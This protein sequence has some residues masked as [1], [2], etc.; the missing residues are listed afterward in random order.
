MRPRRDGKGPHCAPIAPPLRPHARSR[1]SDIVLTGFHNAPAVVGR[2]PCGNQPTWSSPSRRRSVQKFVSRVATVLRSG[3]CR[4]RPRHRLHPTTRSKLTRCPAVPTRDRRHPC[5]PLTKRQIPPVTPHLISGHR[6]HSSPISHETPE[7]NERALDLAKRLRVEGVACDIDKFEVSPPEG[8][9][10]WMK[11]QTQE[12]DFVI[13]VCTETYARRFAGNETSGKGKGAAREGLLIDQSLYDSGENHRFI[14]VVFDQTDVDHIPPVLKNATYYDLSTDAGYSGLHRALTN[15][16]RFVRRPLGPIPKRLSDLDPH[17]SK[18]TE[19]LHLCPDPLPLE[20][21][22]RVVGQEVSEVATT[23]QRLVN[24]DVVKIEQNVVRREERSAD[25]IPVPSDNVVGSALEAALDFVKNHCNA[26]GRAQI[27]NVVA[28][29]KTA[30]I[31]V[32][33]TPVSNT[34][35]TIQSFLKSSGDKRLVLEVAR[36]SIRASKVSGRRRE[37]VKDEAVAAICGVSWVYQRTGRL[38]EALVEADHSLKLGVAIHWDR[39]TA[40]CNKCLGRLKR[41]ES[42][43]EQDVHQRAALLK[44]S[45]ELLREAIDEFTKLELE[46]EVGD[47]Y[48]LLARTYLLAE[49]RQAAREAIREADERLVDSTT[50]DYLDLQIVMGD[51]MLHTNRRSAETV[52]TDVLTT[53]TGEDDAQKSEIMARAYLQRG[54]VRAALDEKDRALA[55]FRRAAEIWDDL[56]DPTADVAHWEIERTSSWMDKETEGLLTREPVGVRVRVARMVG[57][58]TAGRPVGRSHRKKL[59]RDYLRG[60]VSRAREQFVVDRPVW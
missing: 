17:E 48:S 60:V 8:W 53:K 21:I 58:E 11:R 51:L 35:R 4:E 42:E 37:Q 14:P 10:R 27:M 16:P 41:M 29:A 31:D 38:S 12:S 23:L 25:G 57:N 18:A 9:L 45:V 52:Y 44:N 43:A 26:A 5:F 32:T 24:I 20:V 56:E 59:P 6:Q 34:F 13:V 22:A 28:L 49:N 39:N 36:R 55:D 47:C 3:I 46:A 15:Q 19:L 7:H 2:L 40:F 30:D 50:K 54:K 1:G 33:P